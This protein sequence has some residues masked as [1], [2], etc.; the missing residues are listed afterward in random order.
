MVTCKI[1]VNIRLQLLVVSPPVILTVYKFIQIAAMVTLAGAAMVKNTKCVSRIGPFTGGMKLG[2][3]LA[4][5]LAL[6]LGLDLIFGE[7]LP[8]L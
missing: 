2:S 4:L 8:H 7:L 6:A 5:A 3:G 1:T